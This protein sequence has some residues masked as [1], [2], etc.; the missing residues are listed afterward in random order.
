M[1]GE[2]QT[3]LFTVAAIAGFVGALAYATTTA[4]DNQDFAS[5]HVALD[6]RAEQD[7]DARLDQFL[8][9]LDRRDFVLVRELV[10]IDRKREAMQSLS[11]W[12]LDVD[13]IR[14]ISAP[15]EHAGLPAV[16]FD[17]AMTRALPIGSDDGDVLL[18]LDVRGATRDEGAPTIVDDDT[19]TFVITA[20]EEA[21]PITVRMVRRDGSWWVDQLIGDGARQDESEF[22]V[23]GLDS[24]G[25]M[26]C[27][28]IDRLVLLYPGLD[29]ADLAFSID[30]SG[31]T[32]DRILSEWCRHI[33]GGWLLGGEPPAPTDADIRRVGQVCPGDLDRLRALR[34]EPG[35]R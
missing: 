27:T 28:Y 26:R 30:G 1:S 20:P 35:R 21:G 16:I 13:E 18:A 25:R 12:T 7:A 5:R 33:Q 6:E 15:H 2:R 29:C 24:E 32:D 9:A 34:Q 4:E 8:D 19:Q 31:E 23:P 22:F 14:I 10:S 3:L 17:E 11:R